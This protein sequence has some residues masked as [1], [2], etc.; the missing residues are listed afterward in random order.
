MAMVAGTI[1]VP[2]AWAETGTT[3]CT[4]AHFVRDR[5]TQL[6]T[7][8]IIFNNGDPRNAATIDRLLIHN[9]FGETVH[10]SGPAVGVAHPLNTSFDPPIDVTTVPPLATLFL[11]TIHIWGID[12]VP[13]KAGNQQGFVMSATVVWSKDGDADLF[14]VQVRPQFRERI[15]L[16]DGSFR[17]GGETSGEDSLCFRVGAAQ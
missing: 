5:G 8:D 6:R 4:V 12:P 3:R 9:A 7:T 11:R 2:P 15:A 1:A 14:R 13:G 16:P 17:E 10:D